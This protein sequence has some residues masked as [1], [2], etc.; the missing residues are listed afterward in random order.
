VTRALNGP[1]KAAVA[2]ALLQAC[3]PGLPP[4]PPTPPGAI[5]GSHT[6]AL[7]VVL[8]RRGAT[9]VFDKAIP[10]EA[11]SSLKVG[12]ARYLV[13]GERVYAYEY[14]SADEANMDAVRIHPSGSKV[15]DTFFEWKHRPHFFKAGRVIVFYMGRNERTLALLRQEVGCEIA[16]R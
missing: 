9:V 10:F 8:Q 3:S 14:A 5:P 1:V 15:G 4:A 12:A 6:Q 2:L 7:A 16:G 11:S 13:N